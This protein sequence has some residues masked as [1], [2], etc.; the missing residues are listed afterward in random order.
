MASLALWSMYKTGCSKPDFLYFVRQLSY[1]DLTCEFNTWFIFQEDQ[2]SFE[3]GSNNAHVS[4]L[5]IVTYGL[6]KSWSKPN[7]QRLLRWYCIKE[8]E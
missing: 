2:M 8:N 6:A 3:I 4:H 7:V 1:E 5:N